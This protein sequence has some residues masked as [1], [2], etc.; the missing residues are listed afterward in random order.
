M[1]SFFRNFTLK[2]RLFIPLFLFLVVFTPYAYFDA[3]IYYQ[4]LKNERNLKTRHLTETTFGI[5]ENEYKR[6]QKGEISES[7]NLRLKKTQ[8]K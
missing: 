2:Q 8:N 1:F 7:Q 3:T 5:I 6:Y 4:E